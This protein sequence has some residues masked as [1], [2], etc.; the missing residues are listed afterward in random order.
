MPYLGANRVNNVRTRQVADLVRISH[1]NLER[2]LCGLLNTNTRL[3]AGPHRARLSSLDRR[4]R[5]RS[6]W[7]IKLLLLDV[8][9]I[10]RSSLLLLRLGHGGTNHHLLL[11]RRHRRC[12][13]S[14]GIVVGCGTERTE[15]II[16]SFKAGGLG[17]EAT[18]TARR[19]RG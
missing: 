18:R 16:D 8:M 13:L 9:R 5:P 17:D 19:T 3:G 11:L 12:V 2:G 14:R 15:G 7:S 1:G 10:R 6:L 4:G